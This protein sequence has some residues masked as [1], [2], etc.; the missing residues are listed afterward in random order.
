M[1]SRDVDA[2]AFC[3]FRRVLGNAELENEHAAL[4][5]TH[6]DGVD[7]TANRAVTCPM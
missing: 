2:L 3:S 4:V 7:T 1:S 6:L 5:D